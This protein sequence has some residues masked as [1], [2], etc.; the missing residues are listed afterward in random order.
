MLFKE[1]IGQDKE[2][3]C[4][5]RQANACFGKYL[6]CEELQDS[7]RTEEHLR[8]KESDYHDQYLVLAATNLLEDSYKSV[9]LDAQPKLVDYL[10]ATKWT[11]IDDDELIALRKRIKKDRLGK[12]NEIKNDDD[13][14]AEDFEQLSL[15]K[16]DTDLHLSGRDAL[17][18]F[19]ISILEYG[20][21]RS[22]YNYSMRILLNKAYGKLGAVHQAIKVMQGLDLKHV[23]WDTLGY[24]IFP[25]AFNNGTY[26][27]ALRMAGAAHNM[28]SSYKREVF[29]QSFDGY[30]LLTY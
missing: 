27:D 25:Q 28:Y 15:Q 29:F 26:Q 8:T 4:R 17:I 6:M 30:Y 24:L 22:P 10:K 23:Q 3:S 5:L 2:G 18:T 1:M 20:L 11:E 21:A 12:W 16:D 7:L 9:T 13:H 14:L 19:A